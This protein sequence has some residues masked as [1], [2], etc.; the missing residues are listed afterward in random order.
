MLLSI[1]LIIIFTGDIYA[2]SNKEINENWLKIIDN[3][4]V[5]DNNNHAAFTSMEEWQGNLF[6]AFRE[7]SA[8]HASDTDKGKIRVMQKTRLGWKSQKVLSLDGVDLRDPDF[9]KLNGRF[10]LY[11]LDMRYSEMTPKGWTDLKPIVNNGPGKPVIWKK[12]I[13]NGV[14]Y[15]IGYRWNNWPLLMKSEDGVTWDVVSEYRIGGNANEADMVFVEDTMYVCFRVDTPS[16]SNSI[17]GKSV[18]PYTECQFIVMDI[19]LASPELMALSDDTFLLA[20]RE[21]DYN[22]LSGIRFIYISL[23]EVDKE[24]KIK[25]RYVVEKKSG[26]QGYPSLF[27]AGNDRYYMSYY[28]GDGNTS[29]RMLTFELKK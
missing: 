26:D 2:Q 19:S 22:N 1:F 11:T 4:I 8:H 27:K 29:I 7:G 17:W 14:A 23:F 21:Y 28:V 9:L 13:H 20:A 5:Y 16:G 10:F 18:Y 25:E 24:G 12:R 6:V 15:G 3:S